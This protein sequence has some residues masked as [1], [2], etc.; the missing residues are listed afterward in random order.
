MKRLFFPILIVLISFLIG[1]H[2]F[3]MWRG[4]SLYQTNPSKERLLRAIRLS[5]SNPDPFYKLG[6]FFQLDIRNIDLKESLKY[7]REAIRRNPLEQQY[8]LNL[9]RVLQRMGEKDLSVQALEKAILV[10]PTSYQG[11]WGAANLLLRQGMPEKA[12]SHFA[13][14]LA[15]FPNQSG[16]VYDVLRQT[17]DDPDFILEKVVPKDP[18]SMNQYL[19]YLYEVGDKESAKK[20][21]EKRASYGVKSDRSQTLRH[22]EFLINRGDLNEAYHVW[23]TRLREDG[24]STP[25]D[26]NLITNG[27]FEKK[28][29]MGGGFDW[30]MKDVPGAEIS[31]DHSAAFEGKASLKIV[32]NGKENVNFQHVYQFVALRPETEYVL[33]AHMKTKAVTTKSGIRIEI[34]GVGPAFHGAS[35][36]L[37]ADNGW[38]ELTI[39]FRTPVQSQGGVVRV[40]REKTDKFDRF[41]SG[42]VWVDDIQLKERK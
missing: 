12:L 9:S 14:I 42:T 25:A 16:L 1:T 18:S 4:F 21:W 38:K 22:V 7:F 2:I 26:G 29:I 19:A 40:R 30:K 35:E 24:F 36:A 20:A 32:F 5:P 10:F 13:Y 27:G 6:L 31:F 17:I 3:S 8:Y 28:E 41:I 39:A 23:K 34:S 11:R 15:N 37:I 33:K